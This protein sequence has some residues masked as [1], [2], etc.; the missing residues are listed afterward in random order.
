MNKQNL[1]GRE[2][3]IEILKKLQTGTLK[4]TDFKPKELVHRIGYYPRNES[5]MA[6]GKFVDRD[7]FQIESARQTSLHGEPK[8]VISYGGHGK[9]H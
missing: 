5:F 9:L 3:K 1:N 2:S 6:D 4:A 8:L 7:T